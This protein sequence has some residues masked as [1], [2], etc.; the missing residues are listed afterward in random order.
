MMN[1]DV[2]ILY[3]R[4]HRSMLSQTAKL[5]RNFFLHRLCYT[6]TESQ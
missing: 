3:W 1:K 2:Y 6:N 5:M 4:M